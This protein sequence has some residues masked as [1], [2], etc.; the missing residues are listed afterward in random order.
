[1]ALV[2]YGSLITSMR[3]KVGGHVFQTNRKGDF[4]R[5]SVKPRAVYNSKTNG[6]RNNISAIGALWQGLSPSERAAWAASALTY[7]F[8]N[9]YGVTY[10]P[11]AYELFFYINSLLYTYGIIY[12]T[13]AQDYGIS[14]GIDCAYSDI[15][16]SASTFNVTLDSATG[17][18]SYLVFKCSA[19][20]RSGNELN[21]VHLY[22]LGKVNHMST[23]VFSLF[24]MLSTIFN[25][26]N[27]AGYA[28][29]IT[30]EKITPNPFSRSQIFTHIVQIVS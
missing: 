25:P 14:S 10:T 15:D 11:S 29:K 21:G 20:S 30:C 26:S 4:I 16:I 2:Q 27:Y 8:T 1:M 18:L 19:P 24:S 12:T 5:T 3:G 9:R 6:Y 28:V 7:T 23:L 13:L 22:Y 17:A